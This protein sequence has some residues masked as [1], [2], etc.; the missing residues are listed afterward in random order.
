MTI[1]FKK[2]FIKSLVCVIL[3]GLCGCSSITS[4][5]VPLE[6]Q[7]ISEGNIQITIQTNG[8]AYQEDLDNL[9]SAIEKQPDYLKNKV[10]NVYL[11]N[12]SNLMKVT[13]DD[14]GYSQAIYPDIYFNLVSISNDEYTD[15]VVCHEMWHIYDGYYEWLSGTNEFL[16]LYNTNPSSI[17]DYGAKNSNEF[18]AEAGVKYLM[19][20]EELKQ[21]NIDVYNYFEA[22][23]KE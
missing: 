2:H 7:T 4:K 21:L 14:D 23:P 11:M 22:L 12:A 18:F 20:P 15:E 5:I 16:S 1:F 10:D 19:N 8:K 9:L 17:S 6:D 13:G 3:F